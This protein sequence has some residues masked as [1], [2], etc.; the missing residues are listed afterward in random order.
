MTN[1][2]QGIMPEIA[3]RIVRHFPGTIAYDTETSGLEHSDY[4]VGYVITGDGHSLYVPV[5]HD[6]GGNIPN[7]DEFEEALDAAFQDRSRQGYRTV[8]HNL[9]FDL[10]MS[11]KVGYGGKQMAVRLGS[12]LEDTM[13]NEALI[14][15]RTI[16]YGLDDLAERHKVTHKKGDELYAH[17]ASLF[18]GLPD[19][20][21]MKHFWKL[22]GDD[23]IAVD[24]AT[25]DGISTLEVYEKQQPLLD[26][27]DPWSDKD[28]R[29]VW[30][31]ECDLLPHVA[32]MYS[33][34]IAVDMEYAERVLSED[35]N[36]PLSIANEIKRALGKFEPGFNPRSPAAVEA[37]YRANG[38]T[39]D[40]FA[41]TAQGKP[42][43]TEA[44]LETN[45][46]GESI[47]AVRRL[48]K[49]RDSFITPLV[50]NYNGRVYPTLN[51]SKSD[52]YGVAGARFSCSDPN[53]QAF[54]KRNKVVGRK[55]RPL[56]KSDFGHMYE[57][58]FKQ[59]EPRFFTHYSQQQSLVDAYNSGTMDIHDVADSYFHIGRDYAKRLGLGVLTGLQA[60]SLAVKMRWSVNQAQSAINK[61]LYEAFPDI[62][63]FQ[64]DAKATFKSRGVVRSIL[65][66]RAY[67]DHPRFAYRAVSR[68]IQNSG[69]DHMK[70]A[71]LRAC[72]Y[73][74]SESYDGIDIL[75][76][77]HD[78]TIFQAEPEGKHP[79]AI[80]RLLE[81]VA[82]EPD[83]NLIVPIPV[84]EGHGKH[85]GH[86]SY[87][88]Y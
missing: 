56:L 67:L 52:E 82:Q 74:E 77:I 16:G 87:G 81:G 86:A 42:S 34:G 6:G 55:V 62:A 31:L 64:K 33:K 68:I 53:L 66:R 36:E 58:D 10:R 49:A 70:T 7:V 44:F 22:A 50:N 69:G 80:K 39:D 8:G 83:F 75:L 9:G 18:G 4:V 28:L 88:E 57:D 47:L 51:Q 24:Y 76:T 14:D 26:E 5:R 11:L 46:I 32:R 12:P 85:W 60:E 63:K 43:F 84:D 13:I 79:A 3:L 71:L 61:F 38:Y 17:L 37:L 45:D 15:D 78:S 40:Q 19:R 29:K 41:R 2:V 73:A 23:P 35:P 48:E 21:Q 27:K 25:G 65:G 30:K 54:P 72:Q 1:W 20:K 59:Q